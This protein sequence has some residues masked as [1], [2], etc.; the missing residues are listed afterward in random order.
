MKIIT[1][2]SFLLF[3]TGSLYAADGAVLTWSDCVRSA[4]SYNPDLRSASEKVSQ[5]NAARGIANS[6]VLPR[7]DANAGISKSRNEYGAANIVTESNNYSY[8]VTARQLLFDGFK[9]IYDIKYANSSLEISRYDYEST[10]AQVRYDL[11]YAF[12]QLLKAQ[13]SVAIYGEI[14]DLRKK[15]LELV[16]M[17]YLAG[18][19]HKG[20]LL[21][22]EANLAQAET[23]MS[24]AGRNLSL[25]QRSLLKEMGIAEFRPIKVSG[26]LFAP[27]E[28]KEKP[29]F[30]SIALKSPAFK[31]IREQIKLSEYDIKS[32]KAGYSPEIYA[33]ASAG[34]NGTDP[35]PDNT[36]LSAGVQASLNIFGGGRDYASVSKA[37]AG[38]R[39]LLADEESLKSSLTAGLENKWITWRNSMDNLKI[40]QK[41][42]EAAE[43]RAKIGEAQYSI[44]VLSFD[45][46]IIIE[47]NLVNSKKALLNAAANSLTAEAEW[48]QGKGETLDYD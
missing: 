4:K 1:L 38:Y 43:E 8:S 2:F 40:Q 7:I 26:D 13:E 37:E 29:D 25:Y 12:V 44:G 42:L 22:A 5:K 31:S 27:A 6:A 41:F 3:I 39:Q 16:R 9:S 23:D 33:T 34:K 47:D 32:A 11:R 48:A 36:F 35:V 28:A 30:N 24:Q 21:T 45:N 14:F 46:W 17:R 10:S 20:S 18:R 19:E 15:N